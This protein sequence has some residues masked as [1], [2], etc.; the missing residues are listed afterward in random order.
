MKR[1]VLLVL[2]I[3]AAVVVGHR[4]ADARAREARGQSRSHPV[5]IQL[6]GGGHSEVHSAS[7]CCPLVSGLLSLVSRAPQVPEAPRVMIALRPRRAPRAPLP[8]HP[9]SPPENPPPLDEL[10]ETIAAD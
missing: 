9:P 8:P 4:L 1:F 2:L 3:Y 7:P 10:D 5:R 6:A